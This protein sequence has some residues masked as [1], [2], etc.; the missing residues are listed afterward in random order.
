[1][2]FQATADSLERGFKV[3]SLGAHM[4]IA[5]GIHLAFDRLKEIQ[6]NALQIFTTNHRQWRSGK[7]SPEAIGLF[8]SRWGQTGGIPVASHGIYLVNL[9]ARDE[10]ILSRSITA[11]AEELMR[12]AALGIKYLTMHPGA[13]LGEGTEAGLI[14]FVKNLDR[15]IEASRVESVS[16]LIENTAGQG[17]SLGSTFEEISFILTNS[18]FGKTM[19]VCYDTAHG[20]GAGYDIRDEEAYSLTLSRFDETIGIDRLRFFHLND[21]KREL[22]S[23]V[24]RH[25]HIGKGKIGLNGFR[26]LLNDPRFRDH[27]MVLETPKGKDLKEDKENMRVLRSLIRSGDQSR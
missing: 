9:A 18:G 3:P 19:G 5:G 12:C 26:L 6:G 22:G 23:R 1:M 14:H 11:L 10:L 24:D 21:S 15:A 7:L 17:S 27:P 13:H 2:R 8:K 16:I 20:F 25:E 4:S